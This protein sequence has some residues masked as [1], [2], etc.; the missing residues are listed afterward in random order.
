MKSKL[1]ESTHE[2]LNIF[3]NLISFNPYFRMTA[4][5]CIK[6]PVFDSVRNFEKE[7]IL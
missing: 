6:N 7:S 1:S 3:Q 4:Y 2:I 5:E